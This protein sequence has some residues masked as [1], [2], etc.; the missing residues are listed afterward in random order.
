MRCW[1]RQIE[2]LEESPDIKP[3]WGIPFGVKDVID[4]CDMPTTWGSAIY[5][6]YQPRREAGCVAMLRSAGAIVFG[7]TVS[8]EFAF[9]NP[10]KTRNPH[11]IEHTPGGSSQGS[12]AAVADHMIPFALGTQ[13]AASVIRPASF[14]GV[15]GYKSSAGEFDMGGVC[16]L[17]QSMDSLG[18]FVRDVRDL[19]ILRTVCLSVDR[20]P[21]SRDPR[22]VGFVRTP[23]WDHG[24]HTQPANAGRHC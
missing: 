10:G 17:S 20:V 13:T 23:H 16:S 24:V 1:D 15:V 22:I 2:D 5:H 6:D 3:L 11:N 19:A 4:T 8:T 14:C 21:A 9:L 7:K 12:A 18:F